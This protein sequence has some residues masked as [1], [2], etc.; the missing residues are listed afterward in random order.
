MKT[1][2]IICSIILVAIIAL[3]FWSLCAMA[4][5]NDDMEEEQLK[6]Y[7]SKEEEENE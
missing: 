3:I 2:D 7:W 4:R 5:R 6:E 1:V